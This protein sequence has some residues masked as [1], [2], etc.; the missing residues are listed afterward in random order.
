M[1]LSAGA[2]DE[3]PYGNQLKE[4]AYVVGARDHAGDVA[5]AVGLQHATPKLAYYAGS[6]AALARLGLE[7]TALSPMGL[8]RGAGKA[9]AG[10]GRAVVG[11]GKALVG[12]GRAAGNAALWA[13]KNPG[14][15]LALG[16]GGT[17]L[18]LAGA[19]HF[20]GGHGH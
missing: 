6:Q 2:K 10:T 1:P 9:V 7:K 19:G 13:A 18:G 11:T 3:M 17:A 20:I 8:V 15:T 5:R 12:A 4:T 16:A 14:K